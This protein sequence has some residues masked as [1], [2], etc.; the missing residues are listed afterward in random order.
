MLSKLEE[1]TDT[2]EFP[3]AFP[4]RSKFKHLFNTFMDGD[5]KRA[6][7]ECNTRN[8][9]ANVSQGLRQWITRTQK[10]KI[11]SRGFNVYLIK[12]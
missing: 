5:M 12:G 8:E 10:I 9:V 3:E 2:L 11:M 1:I 7:I 6:K 4:G